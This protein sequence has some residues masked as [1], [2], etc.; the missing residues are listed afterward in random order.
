M[1]DEIKSLDKLR[2]RIED[3]IAIF[4]YFYNDSCAPCLSL[5]PKIIEMINE[6]FPE[7]ELV[8]V[9]SKNHMEIASEYGIFET[10][11]MIAFFDGKESLRKGKYSSI[12][13]IKDT[14][15]RYYRM[16]FL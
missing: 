8:F 2:Q 5:R 7:M 12:D 14:M 1:T 16:L 10:P 3:S 6:D 4:V 11:T 9:N 15:G 13:N